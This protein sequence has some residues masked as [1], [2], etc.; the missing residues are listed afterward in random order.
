MGDPAQPP[1][2]AREQ[3]ARAKHLDDNANLI[4]GI[5]EL[6]RG[7]YK[8]SEYGRV[9]LPLVVVRRLDQ[10]LEDT[11]DAVLAEAARLEGMGVQ[12]LERGLRPTAGQQFFN[13][14]ALRFPQLLND[15]GQI[16]T[17][18]RR[19]L[20]G[21]SSLAQEVFANFGFDAQIDRL[22]RSNLLYPVIA[23]I[24]DVDLHP[25]RV[26]SQEM[27]YLF[28]R[29]IRLFAEASNETA[30]E[31]FT[32]REV[33]QLMVDLLLAGD[34]Q[35]LTDKAPIREVYDCACG[36]GGMLSEA[37]RHIRALNDSAKVRLFG[38][39]LNGES[40]AICLADML[41]K[42]QDASRITH[43][44]TLSDDQHVGRRFHYG[45][46]NPPFGVDWS[47]VEQSVREE[48]ARGVDGR[49]AAGLPRRS[50]GQ[51]LFLLNL[52]AH[53]R[54]RDEDGGRVAIV[55]NGSPLFTGAAGSGESE[56]RRYLID[57][58]M[59]E[60]IVALPEQ[61]FYNTGIA[62]Y[63]W[64]V[65]NRKSERREGKVQLVDARDMFVKMQKS[66]GDKRRRI[67]DDLIADLGRLY[68]EFEENGQVK[69]MSNDAFGY[70]TIVVEQPLRARWEVGPDTW[71]GVWREKTMDKL[72]SESDPPAVCAALAQ[73]PHAKYMTEKHASDA[74]KEAVLTTLPKVPAPL[75]KALVAR[76]VVRDAEAEPVRDS[77]GR[78]IAD[79]DL[80]DYEDVPLNMDVEEYL[81]RD[82]RV[83]AP[84]AWCPEPSGKVGYEIPFT[85]V[86]YRYVAPRPSAEIKEELRSLEADV[87]QL[88]AQLTA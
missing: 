39:E 31:H 63:V 32:P 77:K 2:P 78:L 11:K 51:L 21:Y 28:E 54:T 87:G 16:E 27:G 52:V 61:L 80:R 37:E 38:Q 1:V 8:R 47:K 72:Y 19:Y 56:I 18:L 73:M 60:A 81:E 14:S 82:V 20:D 83:H 9:I 10:A 13:R 25:D 43:G 58:D 34:E 17:N 65:T 46:A 42:D 67:S 57:N 30:G 84:G 75:L 66:L 40:Y 6:L 88:L 41:L 85:K 64:V 24:C 36:T 59:L 70:R 15:P 79:P 44:N 62:T 68:G 74:I 50:D 55:F 3:A 33:V 7:D 29:L 76:T 4:W 53:M 5:A 23:R 12:N 45:I 69:I 71:D 86:F 26:E 35:A 22:A 48:H 49:F